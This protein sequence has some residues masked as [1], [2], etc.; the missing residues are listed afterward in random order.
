MTAP[1]ATPTR[2]FPPCA[3]GNLRS[4]ADH[5]AARPPFP[6]AGDDDTVVDFLDRVLERH[7]GAS[8]DASAA[9]AAA[10]QAGH[11]SRRMAELSPAQARSLKGDAIDALLAVAIFVLAGVCGWALIGAMI[12]L[13]G[14]S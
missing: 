5:R 12:A 10:R 3:P 4:G 13:W 6:E 7:D 8:A 2:A 14:Q 9:A 1:D 11:R